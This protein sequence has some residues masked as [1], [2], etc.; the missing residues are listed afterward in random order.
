[1]DLSKLPQNNV[2]LKEWEKR[3]SQ[4]MFEVLLV[5]KALNNKQEIYVCL[6]TFKVLWDNW[7]FLLRR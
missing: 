3:W 6:F 7:N 2:C 1:M 5:Q 4:K